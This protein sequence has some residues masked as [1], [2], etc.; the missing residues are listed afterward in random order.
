MFFSKVPAMP[1]DVTWTGEWLKPKLTELDS[2]AD[3]DIVDPQHLTIRRHELPDVVVTTTSLDRLDAEA[4]RT[5]LEKYPDTDIVVNI[6]GHL[7]GD[8]LALASAS[9][10]SLLSVGDAMRALRDED[11]RG[12]L[13]RETTYRQRMLRQH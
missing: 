10:V 1:E 8:A 11:V 3:V 7:M 6:R 9:N 13:S 2:V 12:Y 5:L 4:F